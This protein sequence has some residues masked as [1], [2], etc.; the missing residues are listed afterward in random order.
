MSFHQKSKSQIWL[1]CG[2]IGNIFA[3]YQ[4]VFINSG[5]SDTPFEPVRIILKRNAHKD[6]KRYAKGWWE[7]DTGE[8]P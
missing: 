8:K 1:K 5:H 3:I 4:E 2:A 6:W 7:W